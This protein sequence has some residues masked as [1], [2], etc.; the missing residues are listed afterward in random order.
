[1]LLYAGCWAVMAALLWPAFRAKL[2][3]RVAPNAQAPDDGLFLGLCAALVGAAIAGMV[4]HH[5]VR[6]PHLISLLWVVAAL[7]VSMA[8]PARV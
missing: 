6:F 8:R 2:A 1:M 5:F 3:E 7:A 4:D